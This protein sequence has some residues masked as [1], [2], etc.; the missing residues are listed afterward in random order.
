MKPNVNP[1]IIRA[2][3]LWIGIGAIIQP[4]ACSSDD[5]NGPGGLCIDQP[6]GGAQGGNGAS[7]GE[8][9]SSGDAGAPSGGS[10]GSRARGGAGGSSAGDGG[11]DDGGSSGDGSDTGGVSTG[12]RGGTAARGGTSTGGTSGDGSAGEGGD[13]V[14]GST[15]G[16]AGS[17]TGGVAGKAGSGGGPSLCHPIADFQPTCSATGGNGCITP[18]APNADWCDTGVGPGGASGVGLASE[19]LGAAGSPGTTTYFPI[20][21]FED[22]DTWS[23]NVF[24]AKGGWYTV[25]NCTG[26]LQFPLPCA[27]PSPSNDGSPHAS[28]FAMHT[29]G[30]GFAPDGFAQVGLALRSNA[31]TCDGALDAGAAD[32]VSFWAKGAP[33]PI[34]Y[35]PIRFAIGTVATNPTTD[36]GTCTTGCWN[37]HGS[38]ITV[39]P[40]WHQYFV[41]FSELAQ[42]NW[43]TMVPFDR[44]A[45]LGFVWAARHQDMPQ[46][47]ASC[48]D[49]W[50]DDVAFFHD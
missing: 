11:S 34:A 40:D 31:P 50:I 24:G 43:G 7:G 46:A 49:F 14:G 26:G 4:I 19:E 30:E 3:A 41:R 17:A 18:P 20:E 16:R 32:G 15:G 21:D 8:G 9:A 36:A 6:G 35:Q 12:G 44:H 48:F 28:A 2:V 37:A 5:C 13:S 23:K 45:I 27:T 22:G 1:S 29:F 39:G 10:A 42:E 25:N 38:F 47:Q 33:A